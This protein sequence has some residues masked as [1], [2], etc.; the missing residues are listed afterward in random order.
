MINGFMVD[1]NGY[2]T[3]DHKY[4]GNPGYRTGDFDIDGLPYDYEEY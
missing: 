2:E 3:A 4:L 1:K